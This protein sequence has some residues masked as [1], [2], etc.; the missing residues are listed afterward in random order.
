M[1]DSKVTAVSE[2]CSSPGMQERSRSG[3]EFQVPCERGG[4]SAA[5]EQLR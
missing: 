1:E 2:V 4:F 3:R 5:S